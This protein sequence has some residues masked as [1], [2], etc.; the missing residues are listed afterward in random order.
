[1]LLND[2]QNTEIQDLHE[3]L[4]DVLV[5]VVSENAEDNQYI[6]E[7][8]E[9]FCATTVLPET[10]EELLENL[11]QYMTERFLNEMSKA[12]YSEMQSN[13]FANHVQYPNIEQFF[14]SRNI[15]LKK[16]VNDRKELLALSS[17][18]KTMFLKEAEI[19][20]LPQDR[21]EK[22]VSKE[23]YPTFEKFT[24]KRE[25]A[26]QGINMSNDNELLALENTYANSWKTVCD[27]GR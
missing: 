7:C 23:K 18:M 2:T 25:L 17:R 26:V 20:G 27:E 11:D 6:K 10:K 13:A 24:M 19:N 1:M 5:N 21:A 12:G 22:Y 14:K 15:A 4:V 8:I 3:D 16:D 9:D